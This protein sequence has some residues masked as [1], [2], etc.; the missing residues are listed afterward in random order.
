MNHVPHFCIP[1]K[2]KQ[3]T[4]LNVRTL[5]NIN[6]TFYYQEE[7]IMITSRCPLL[8]QMNHYTWQEQD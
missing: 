5:S 2:L 7:Q 8:Y 3:Y 6:H 1:I 4:K